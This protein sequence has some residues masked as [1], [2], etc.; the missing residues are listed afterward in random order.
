MNADAANLQ[1][2]L[3]RLTYAI[4]RIASV[5]PPDEAGTWRL[6]QDDLDAARHFTRMISQ[7]A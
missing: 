6:V 5:I 4:D 3:T 7:G 1:A 2:A